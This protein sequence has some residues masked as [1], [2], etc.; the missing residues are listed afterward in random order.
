MKTAVL[1]FASALQLQLV[2]S[3]L[4]QNK[5][6]L[7]D[8]MCDATHGCL[9]GEHC[10]YN[11][12]DTPVGCCDDG[13]VC[14]VAAGTCDLKHE[15]ATVMKRKPM[16]MNSGKGALDHDLVGKIKDVM[17]DATS[18]CLDGEHCCFNT[19][20][21]PAGCCDDGFVCDVPA[22]TCDLKQENGTVMTSNGKSMRMKSTN[23]TKKATVKSADPSPY[24]KKDHEFGVNPCSTS[25]TDYWFTHT[26]LR[27]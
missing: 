21:I 22:G 16:K 19:D 24:C 8:V 23:A 15:N 2:F 18:S 12:D 1:L 13:F 11:T 4:T 3:N 14:D 20:G 9:D 5:T 25:G 17:C 6:K 10:C 27:H 7:K 26:A